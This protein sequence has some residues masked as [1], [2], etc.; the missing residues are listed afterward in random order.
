[1]ADTSVESHTI[2]GYTGYLCERC[3]K[4]WETLSTPSA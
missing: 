4:E 2:N 1:M 3:R